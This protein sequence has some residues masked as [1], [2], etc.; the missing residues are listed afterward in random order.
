MQGNQPASGFIVR[1][2]S[3]KAG[4]VE[5]NVRSRSTRRLLGEIRGLTSANS[6]PRLT[7]N[8]HC[9]VCEFRPACERQAIEDDK[10]SLLRGIG[11]KAVKDYGRRGVFTITQLAHMFRPRRKSTSPHRVVARLNHALSALAIK[12]KMVYIFAEPPNLPSGVGAYLDVE[13]NP[14]E[15]Y[16]YLIGMVVTGLDRERR[17]SFWADSKDQAGA[18]FELFLDEL[19]PFGEF[20]LYCY[21]SF[22]KNFLGRM[23]K[24]SSR[25]DLVDR[26]LRSLVNV[27]SV[28]YTHF[29]FPTYSNGLKELARC[30]GFE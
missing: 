4:K 15:G 19:E 16:V 13:C 7:L 28:V 8:D 29:Y 9:Q 22:E 17:F 14:E 20:S 1:G 26:A 5:F 21:G 27:L 25:P 30:L 3:L 10:V 12:E 24:R 23:R 6:P 2:R 18:I 11:R